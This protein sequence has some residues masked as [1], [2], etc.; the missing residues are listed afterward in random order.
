MIYTTAIVF[1]VVA[2]VASITVFGALI[3]FVLKIQKDIKIKKK[4]A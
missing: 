4:K 1:P 2:L 3:V